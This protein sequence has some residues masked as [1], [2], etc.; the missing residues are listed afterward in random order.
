MG[1]T[2]CKEIS[3]FL[4]KSLS[5]WKF[6]VI[7]KGFSHSLHLI[8]LHLTLPYLILTHISKPA[9]TFILQCQIQ[10]SWVRISRARPFWWLLGP[11]QSLPW[12]LD[13]L[14][15]P[16]TSRSPLQDLRPWSWGGRQPWNT[17]VKFW[18]RYSNRCSLCFLRLSVSNDL[19]RWSKKK[20]AS[21]YNSTS[22]V[23]SS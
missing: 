2:K 14:T 16:L 21:L 7:K 6:L 10:I 9:N 18:V 23:K 17:A 3:F 19:N 4:W 8:I 13:L 12:Q 1:I 11:R 22:A 5:V 15:R 20:V